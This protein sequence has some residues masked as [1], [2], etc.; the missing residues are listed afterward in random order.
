M[1][2]YDNFDDVKTKLGQTIIYYKGQAVFV[3]DIQPIPNEAGDI[4]IDYTLSIAFQDK[5]NMQKVK[6]SDV[7]NLNYLKYQ[8]GYANFHGTAIYW[9]RKPVKQYKQ[10]LKADQMHYKIADGNQMMQD[11]PWN[12]NR[13]VIDMLEGRYPTFKEAKELIKMGVAKVLAFHK[14]F[15]FSHNPVFDEFELEYKG[16]KIGHTP[17]FVNINLTDKYA[18]V[19]EA[20][21]EAV[22]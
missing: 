6:L 7:D 3:K 18:Y 13:P 4:Y 11:Q 14:D 20:L 15:A 21:M 8:L 17:D 2:L 16:V 5:R 10:G 22:A 12:F 1:L 9:Y 19:K